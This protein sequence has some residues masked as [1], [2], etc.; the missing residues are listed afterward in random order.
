[1]LRF[2]FDIKATSIIIITEAIHDENAIN[3]TIN[4]T[5]NNTIN[6]AGVDGGRRRNGRLRGSN[7]GRCTGIVH[8]ATTSRRA[9]Y[10]VQLAIL[11]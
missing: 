5:T 9:I 10:F 8:A 7:D 6:N 11:K 2:C 1:M 4:N 3:N